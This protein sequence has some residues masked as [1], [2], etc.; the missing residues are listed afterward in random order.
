MGTVCLKYKY[1]TRLQPRSY[2][3]KTISLLFSSFVSAD[4]HQM[5]A[6]FSNLVRG[7]QGTVGSNSSGMIF[8]IETLDVLE[9]YGCYCRFDSKR[10]YLNGQTLDKIDQ[11]CKILQDGYECAIIDSIE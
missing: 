9:N 5:A 7:S 4:L 6:R 1:H 2:K 3:M 11:C 10:Q 8:P